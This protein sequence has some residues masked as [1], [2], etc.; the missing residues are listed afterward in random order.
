MNYL[1]N[2]QLFCNDI[3]F[4]FLEYDSSSLNDKKGINYCNLIGTSPKENSEVN[5][6]I[7]M[8]AF[9]NIDFKKNSLNNKI[10]NKNKYG[11]HRSVTEKFP[12]KLS[13]QTLINFK[14]LSISIPSFQINNNNSIKFI[15]MI[16]EF[17][18]Y[19]RNTIKVNNWII[20]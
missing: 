3:L 15:I 12:K 8:I 19:K 17:Y 14:C 1:I 6:Q 10:N 18:P 4:E 7:S 2:N 20:I 16:E 11:F 13:H 9:D 5:R